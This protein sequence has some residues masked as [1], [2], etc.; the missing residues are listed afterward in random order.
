MTDADFENAYNS[1]PLQYDDKLVSKEF[2]LR[3]MQEF[4]YENRKVI[5]VDLDELESQK[6]KEEQKENTIIEV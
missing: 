5:L 2:L 1:D 4:F 3:E 6:P